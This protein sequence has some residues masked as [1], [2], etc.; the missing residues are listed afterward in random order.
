MIAEVEELIAAYEEG[1][2]AHDDFL[3]R[4]L[5]LSSHYKLDDIYAALP[6]AWQA[7]F[8]SWARSAYDNDV[9]PEDFVVITQGT[10]DDSHLREIPLVREWLARRR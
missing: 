1:V 5:A 7:E 4:L 2:Y 6:A 9:P 3:G 8:L 10:P